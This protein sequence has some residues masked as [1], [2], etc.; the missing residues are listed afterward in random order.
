MPEMFTIR[1][2]RPDEAPIIAHHRRAMFEAMGHTDPATLERVERD[3]TAWVRAKME[4]GEYLAWF[5][6]TA[7]GE[8]VAGGGVWL[9]E[10]PPHPIDTASL[11]GHVLNVYTEPA[12]RRLGLARRIMEA[13]VADCEQ[14]RL[15]VMSLHA[16]D[17]GR[18]L[19]ESLGFKQTNEMRRIRP[20]KPASAG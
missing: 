19:Y 10:S 4:Q 6:V 1:Q 16:T 7:D 2:A 5:A 15:G 13:I 9:I 12:Y 18:P 11:R 20:A 17:Q 14:R 3:F 8:V